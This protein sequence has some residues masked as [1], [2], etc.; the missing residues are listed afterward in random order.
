MFKSYTIVDIIWIKKVFVHK[1]L[2]K[3]EYFVV[4]PLTPICFRVPPLFMFPPGI[5]LHAIN[6]FMDLPPFPQDIA[7]FCPFSLYLELLAGEI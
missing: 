7:T 2:V 6:E 5:K 3:S 1:K 4:L